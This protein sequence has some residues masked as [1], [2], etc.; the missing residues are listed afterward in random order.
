LN[1]LQDKITRAGGLNRYGKPNFLLVWG[2]SWKDRRGGTWNANGKYFRGYKEVVEEKRPTWILKQWYAPEEFGTPE[3]WYLTNI[4]PESGLQ[5]LGEFPYRGMYMTLQTL[6][7]ARLVN[8]ELKVEYM[9]LNS[10]IV[11][12]LV[13][14]AIEAKKASFT[15]RKI[16]AEALAAKE[17]KDLESEIEARRNNA[18]LAFRGPVSFSR[19]GCRTSLVDKKAHELNQMWNVISANARRVMQR[20]MGISQA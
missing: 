2:P 15:R 7:W 10:E 14:L 3:M 11:D 6:C 13:P 4:E 9:P 16:A 19:Q 8:G 12:M 1:N 18:R 17:E 20:G 5:L